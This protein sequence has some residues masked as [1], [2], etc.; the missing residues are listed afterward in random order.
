MSNAKKFEAGIP[1]PMTEKDWDEWFKIR[2]EI[3]EMGFAT[4][5]INNRDEARKAI[6]NVDGVNI[7][8]PALYRTYEQSKR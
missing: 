4:Y 1:V 7:I 2:D 5:L 8:D 3:A 6:R